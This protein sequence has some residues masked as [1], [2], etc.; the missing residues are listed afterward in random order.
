M[1]VIRNA[2]NQLASEHQGSYV[3]GAFLAVCEMLFK[4]RDLHP[5]E[6]AG[7]PIAQRFD[8]SAAIHPGRHRSTERYWIAVALD[9]LAARE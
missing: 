8:E 3:R 5:G 4:P 1:L 9:S 6:F 7:L 2:A